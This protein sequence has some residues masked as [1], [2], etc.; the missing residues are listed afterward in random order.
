MPLFSIVQL[1]ITTHTGSVTESNPGE[2]ENVLQI[3]LLDDEKNW[4]VLSSWYEREEL[5]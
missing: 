2:I 4:K 1:V 3:K 5:I